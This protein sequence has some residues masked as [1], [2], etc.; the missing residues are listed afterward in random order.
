MKETRDGGEVRAAGGLR[1]EED[2]ER[3]IRMR[4]AEACLFISKK[5][6]KWAQKSRKS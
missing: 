6:N 1:E 3:E 2:G 5:V 4:K